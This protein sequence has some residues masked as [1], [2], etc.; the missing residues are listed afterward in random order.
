MEELKPPIILLGNVRSGTSMTR[1]LFEMHPSVTTIREPRT[2]WMYADPGRPHDRFTEEDATPRVRRYIRKRFLGFQRER[3]GLRLMEKTPSNLM[4]IPF[5]HKV[6]PEARYLYLIREPFANLSSSELKWQN[7]I[8][9][10]RLM[11]RLRETPKTQLH[12][13]AWRLFWDRFSR[14]VLKR[15]HVSVWGVRYPGIYEDLTRMT[16]EEVIAKQW[17]ECSRQ[18]ARDLEGIPDDL[19]YRVRYED[20]VADPV[21]RFGDILRHFDLEPTS[22]M[23]QQIAEFVDPNRQNKWRRMD[24]DVMRRCVPILREEMAHHGY[25]VP[26]DVEAALAGE[27]EFLP[28]AQPEETAAE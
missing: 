7:P 11:Q 19:V 9:R 17:V 21:N 15:K 22:E 27:R 25:S 13:Y 20:L 4:R 26:E 2:V 10:V 8:N 12:Y 6:F 16:V 18:S 1:E 14:R 5:V 28:T 3:G 23:H 24:I